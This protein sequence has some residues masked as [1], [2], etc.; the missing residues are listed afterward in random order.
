MNGLELSR[1]YF[2]NTAEPMLKRDFPDVFPRLAAGLAGNGSECF[3]YDDEISRDHDWGVDFYIWTCE[4]DSGLIAALHNWKLKLLDDHPPDFRRERSE[5][6]ARIGVITC[7]DFY[8]SLIGCRDTPKTTDEWVR[9]PEENYAL[10]VNGDVFIDGPGEFTKTRSGLLGYYP[11]DIRRKKI[12][13]KCMGLAQTGQYNHERTAKRRDWVTLR[14]VLSRFTD[15]AL[16]MVF[17]LN[18]VYRPYYKWAFRAASGLPVL[19][20][21][22]AQLLLKISELGGLDGESFDVRQRYI[23]ELCALFSF[24]LK[25]QGL[26]GTEESFLALHGEDIQK[27][28]KDDVLRSL[29]AQYEI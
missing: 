29:P 6:G 16:A 9:A 18:K 26:S 22:T 5:Y 28:I 7:G 17:L 27:N 14:G 4:S 3:G 21:E 15:G 12:A 13:A 23:D 2:R 8:Y 25:A 24:E 11:E 19:G 10:A 1:T 20:A